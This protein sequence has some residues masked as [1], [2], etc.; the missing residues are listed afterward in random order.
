M[1]KKA[2]LHRTLTERTNWPAEWC[3]LW[4]NALTEDGYGR[5]WHSG[6]ARRAHIVAWEAI[7][8]PVPEGR[9]LD[10][11]CGNRA[12][13]HPGHLEA[14]THRENL[15][16]GRTLAAENAAKTECPRGHSL[17]DVNNLAPWKLRLGKR[18]CLTCSRERARARAARPK[19]VIIRGGKAA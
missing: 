16:R 10:H 13:V 8:G 9:E 18:E 15:L 6:R 19:L 3:V 5:V 14:V 17:T 7:N 12:C 1:S 2:P 11:L 4:E